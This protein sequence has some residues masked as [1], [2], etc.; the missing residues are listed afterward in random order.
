MRI[1]FVLGK[2][3]PFAG[4]NGVCVSRIQEVL[5]RRGIESDIVAEGED[6]WESISPY[7]KIYLAKVENHS[8]FSR[9]KR[10]LSVLRYPVYFP[11][12]ITNY[13]YTIDHALSDNTYDA[14]IAVLKPLDGA[15]AASKYSNML[16][17]ELDSIT[18]NDDNQRGIRRLLRFRAEKYEL[19]LYEKSN[20]IF[21]MMSHRSFY[22]KDK[23]RSYAKK[24]LFLDIPQLVNENIPDLPKEGD[25]ATIMYSGILNSKMRSPEY[26]ISLINRYVALFGENIELNFFSR[27]NC[28]N[29]LEIAQNESNGVIRKRG[30]VSLDEL[31]KEVSSTDFLLSIGNNLTG[32]VTSLPSKVISYMAYGKPIIHIDAGKNDVAKKYLSKYPLSI[33]INPH[34]ELQDN[35]KKLNTFINE[36]KGKRVPFDLVESVFTMNTPAFTA[37]CF[38]QSI[39]RYC[40]G[41]VRKARIH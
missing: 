28:E 33:I 22:E 9:L 11:N 2:Y 24:T 26:V 39:S 30:Y 31:N 16:L 19:K 29:L 13:E 4:A 38:E 7:G 18:N 36:C 1:L 32:Q 20:A 21:H 6:Y 37:N 41:T 12:N 14:I 25:K 17:Y 10:Y 15:I 27:G 8:D 5:F 23:Y 40:S 34:F 3:Y 35:V